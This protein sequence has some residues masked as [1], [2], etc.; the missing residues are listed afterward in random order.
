MPRRKPV[1]VI[2]QP[3]KSSSVA[4]E[5]LDF[6]RCVGG[7]EPHGSVEWIGIPA[8]SCGN[9]VAWTENIF[10]PNSRWVNGRG[11]ECW[12]S[13]TLSRARFGGRSVP[14]RC[15]VPFRA[16]YLL[17]RP[18]NMCATARRVHDVFLRE[19][20]LPQDQTLSHA[21]HTGGDELQYTR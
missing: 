20:R 6:I 5:R 2:R 21:H 19:N 15:V 18:V 16:A 17:R 13:A 11:Y 8:P 9:G 3:S 4:D 12:A 1:G 10:V 7:R 14:W